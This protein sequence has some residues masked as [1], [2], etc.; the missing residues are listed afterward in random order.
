MN[1]KRCHRGNANRRMANLGAP[2]Q[3]NTVN[4]TYLGPTVKD[5]LPQNLKILA[6]DS[7]R[8]H[9]RVFNIHQK[10]GSIPVVFHI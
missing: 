5:T 4:L 9:T 1:Q 2:R 10:L 7:N 8:L 6:L 3:Y